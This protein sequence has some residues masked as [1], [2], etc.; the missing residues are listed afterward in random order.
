MPRIAPS[1]Y[2][3]SPSSKRA[4]QVECEEP[5]SNPF[6]HIKF[7]K[8]LSGAMPCISNL[9]RVLSS[10]T[11][12]QKAGSTVHSLQQQ[13]VNLGH[14]E[15]P[16]SRIVG[17]IGDSAV[18]KSSLINSL[19]DKPNLAKSS[20]NGTAC[21]CTV[22]E[23]VYHD[24]DNFTIRVQYF[25]RDE[26]E[27]QLKDLVSAYRNIK[28]PHDTMEPGQQNKPDLQ[29]NKEA[30]VHKAN[31]ARQTF[32]AI[33]TRHLKEDPEALSREEFNVTVE[34]MMLWVRELLPESEDEESFA[35]LQE[36]ADRLVILTSGTGDSFSSS[37]SGMRW[38]L[39]KS[40]KVY[41]R[42]VILSKGLILADVPG[43]RDSNPV[44][45][46]ITEQYIR[47]CDQ[48][49]AVLPIQ[50]AADD[51]SL[52][53]IFKL[54]QDA[55]LCKVDIVCTKSEDVNTA[56]AA[57]EWAEHKGEIE[58]LQIEMDNIRDNINEIAEALAEEE[59]LGFGTENLKR[60]GR[61]QKLLYEHRKLEKDRQCKEHEL[62]HRLIQIR[63]T[64]V[65]AKLHH[66]Y[67]D[68]EAAKR[69]K[70]FCVSHIL[71][72]DNRTG[73]S[74]VHLAAIRI[75][76]IPDLRRH[77]IGIIAESHYRI[78]K[79]LIDHELPAF[80]GSVELW[81][82]SGGGN[83]TSEQRRI[84]EILPKI[85]GYLLQVRNQL[86]FEDEEMLI[87]AMLRVLLE[88]FKE[89]I[90]DRMISSATKWSEYAE[91]ASKLWHEWNA[92]TYSAFCRH[93][94]DHSTQAVG[95]R[96]WNDE[97]I[98]C[99]KKDLNS[100]WEAFVGILKGKL[101]ELTDD[102]KRLFDRMHTLAMPQQQNGKSLVLSHTS[103]IRGLRNTLIH[104]RDIALVGMGE[105]QEC[106]WSGMATLKVNTLG[107]LQ[108]A[109]VGECMKK[110]YN[111]ANSEHGP[112]CTKRKRALI[113]GR[114]GSEALFLDM[115]KACKVHF[116]RL[117]EEL[118]VDM[119]NVLRAQISLIERDL[120][121]LRESLAELNRDRDPGFRERV[122]RA[123]VDTEEKVAEAQK[124]VREAEEEM[125]VRVP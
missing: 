97:A 47:Q 33:F 57:S 76:G 100:A 21:T 41:L 79:Q 20:G 61:Y 58:A 88:K 13:A 80:L 90:E 111:E 105:S 30:L 62:P 93:K 63:N 50:R 92:A 1:T 42:A 23:Y 94:G 34:K 22:T 95:Y 28:E 39:I 55:N 59:D 26:L 14:Q 104:R 70:I 122:K 48:I 40:M 36:C 4:Y 25:D 27:Y 99:L 5:P 24:S 107:S 82:N 109:F 86:T 71:Y 81:V 46:R 44:R 117:A 123:M 35:A 19:L 53:N 18:G 96:N 11:L 89:T 43:L 77:C 84:R 16:S 120:Y 65:T 119:C 6:Y 15:L 108:T 68:L 102:I 114:F 9:N 67:K 106:F 10:T 38:P 118:Q 60:N 101:K 85:D 52:D 51:K 110:T 116:A 125:D 3:P 17:M 37:Q 103:A 74:A 115:R 112:G 64:S 7:Q 56:N 69:P 87:H 121:T 31:L 91:K 49:F 29:E 75:S 113:T 124:L 54:A 98:A 45:A 66:K 2:S 8:A 12:H 83:A 72:T 78:S 32:E 73:T